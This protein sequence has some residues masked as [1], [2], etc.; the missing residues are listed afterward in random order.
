MSI[1]KSKE[2]NLVS[3]IIDSVKHLQVLKPEDT[4]FLQEHSKH[5][6]Q[7]VESTHM[8]RTEEQKNQIINDFHFPTL[9]AKFHQAILEQKVQFDQTMYLAKDFELK[10][11]E[12]EELECDLEELDDS[13]R[14]EI[15]SKKIQIEIQF[16]QYELKQM[17]IAMNYR[18]KEIKGWQSIQEELLKKM[19]DQ[20]LNESTIWSKD[21]GEFTSMFFSA[22]N[23]LASLHTTT[24]SAERGN[25]IALATY[26]YKKAK[27]SGK[28]DQLKTMCS[29]DQLSIL[30][31]LES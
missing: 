13:K 24:D 1:I 19:R 21:E 14:S 15:Q 3:N 30:S 25:L 7:V 2:N 20:G 17:E 31:Q 12:I 27:E 9:H 29:N 26:V 8:W 16:K 6:K 23:N 4:K 28:L 22:I 18:M 10:K 5:L 11:L